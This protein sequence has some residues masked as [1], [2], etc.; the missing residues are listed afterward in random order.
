MPKLVKL[1][2]SKTVDAGPDSDGGGA[3]PRSLKSATSPAVPELCS[4]D[5]SSKKQKWTFAFRKRWFSNRSQRLSD[6][7]ASSPTNGPSHRS[8]TLGVTGSPTL[9]AI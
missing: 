2:R 6:E 4:P 1:S 3:S 5:A 7:E 8:V 9:G